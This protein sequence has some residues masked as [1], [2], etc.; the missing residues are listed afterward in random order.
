MLKKMQNLY[1]FFYNSHG[2]NDF[3]EISKNLTR[4][5]YKNNFFKS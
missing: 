4:Y 5:R 3:T 1:V 2:N